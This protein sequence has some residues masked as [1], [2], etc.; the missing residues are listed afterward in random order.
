MLTGVSALMD[1]QVLGSGKDFGTLWEG[2]RERLFSGMHANVVNQLVLGLERF[3]GSRTVQPETCVIVHFWSSHMFHC[4]VR[5]DLR[6]RGEHLVAGD[7]IRPRL[8]ILL[9]D[10]QTADVLLQ[11]TVHVS[12]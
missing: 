5:H 4:D 9:I 6:H 7:V 2:T 11:D 10:P 3:P 8:Q 12:Q 1:L